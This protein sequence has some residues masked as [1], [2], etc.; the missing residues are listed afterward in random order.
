VDLDDV[1]E[2]R[3]V[4]APDRLDDAAFAEFLEHLKVRAM[5][6]TGATGFGTSGPGSAL[7]PLILRLSLTGVPNEDMPCDLLIVRSAGSLE[8]HCLLRADSSAGTVEMWTAA[9]QGATDDIGRRSLTF[10]WSAMVGGLDMNMLS[11][12]RLTEVVELGEV[13]LR[14]VDQP[15]AEL[16]KGPVASVSGGG[17]T[18]RWFWPVIVDGH[19][20]SY[21]WSGSADGAAG[22]AANLIAAYLSLATDGTWQVRESVQASPSSERF[23]NWAPPPPLP[24][25]EQPT[26]VPL[27]LPGWFIDGWNKVV[28]DAALTHAVLMYQE[29][30]ALSEEH[31]SFALVAFASVIE[32]MA[33][34]LDP[35]VACETCGNVPGATRRFKEAVRSVLDPDRAKLVADAYG[36]RSGSVHRS[37]LHADEI[38]RGSFSMPVVVGADASITFRWVVVPGAR[39]AARKLLVLRLTSP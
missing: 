25:L 19:L 12:A 38:T 32:S 15:V 17:G 10:D 36:S 3:Q 34:D 26:A 23:S 31:P 9:V 8:L 13:T 20:E 22:R 1:V 4:S 18:I 35:P 21:G 24:G 16:V 5:E 30:C 14:P 27:A 7:E 29:G 6:A 11:H 2:M 33:A 37:R 28:S 39:T